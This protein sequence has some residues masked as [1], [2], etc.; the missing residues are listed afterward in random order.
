M[1]GDLLVH[2]LDIRR[3]LG[4]DGLHPKVLRELLQVITKPLSIICQQFWLTGE[5]SAD[6]RLANVQSAHTHLYLHTHT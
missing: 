5:V 4:P 6:G 1:V 3:S 2:D